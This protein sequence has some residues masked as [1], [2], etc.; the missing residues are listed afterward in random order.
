MVMYIYLDQK[1]DFEMI[2]ILGSSVLTLSGYF[3]FIS[4]CLLLS[5]TVWNKGNCREHNKV[6]E[7]WSNQPDLS[8]HF[9]PQKIRP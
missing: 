9:E 6:F 7:P 2:L 8:L 1:E 4:Q 5:F 3:F